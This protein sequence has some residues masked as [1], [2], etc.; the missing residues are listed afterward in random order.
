MCAVQSVICESDY[1]FAEMVVFKIKRMAHL[2]DAQMLFLQGMF[3]P[4]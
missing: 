4:Y 3:C 2:T 1:I